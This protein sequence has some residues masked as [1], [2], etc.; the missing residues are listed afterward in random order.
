MQLR[1]FKTKHPSL[2]YYVWDSRP[3]NL[4]AF[5]ILAYLDDIRPTNTSIGTKFMGTDNQLQ[6]NIAELWAALIFQTLP[7]HELKK[8]MDPT[9]IVKRQHLN[10]ANPLLRG[11]LRCS[12]T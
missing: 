11:R 6:I 10:V 3:G 1:I 5:V 12:K 2:H 7:E 4:S 9:T 8:Y